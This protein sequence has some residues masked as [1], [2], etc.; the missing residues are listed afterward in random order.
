MTAFLMFVVGMA[1]MAGLAWVMMRM[2]RSHRQLIERRRE[3]WRAGGSVGPEPGG[4]GCT[5][6]G[7][8]M[9]FGA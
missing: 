8:G 6:G 5:S 4:G 2:Q 7:G 3:E 9:N 1:I